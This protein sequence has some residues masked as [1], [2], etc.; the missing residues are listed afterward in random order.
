MKHFQFRTATLLVGGALA[1]LFAGCS[2]YTT[3]SADFHEAWKV[4]QLQTAQAEVSKK[5][6]NNS[7]NKDTVVWA[8]EEGAVFRAIALEN[9]PAPL[10][11]APAMGGQVNASYDLDMTKQSI[12][13]FDRAADRIATYD[14]QAGTKIASETGALLTNLANL[15]YRGRA[16][17]RIMLE[18][19]QA[20]NYMKLGDFDTA[21]VALNRVLNHQ[22]DAV[23]K[24]S[25]QIEEAQEQ[26][27][28]AKEGKISDEKGQSGSYDTEA[29]LKDPKT[30]AQLEEAEMELNTDV[31][32]YDVYVNPF[33]VFMDGLYFMTH[34]DGSSDMERSR[35]S[36]ER[37]A[38]MSPD[39]TYAREDLKLAE[40]L[41]YGKKPDGLTYLI[42]ETGSAPHLEQ[43]RID[44]PLF[45]VTSKVDYIACALPRLRRDSNF[46][47]SAAISV[48]E[49]TLQTQLLC[50]MDSVVAREFKN[51]WPAVLTKSLIT[52]GIKGAI[53]YEV[54][55]QLGKQGGYAGLLG[56]LAS[57]VFTATTTIADTRSWTT[58]PKEFQYA[59]FVTPQSRTITINAGGQ[60]KIVS[61]EPGKVNLV[62]VKNVAPG[63]PLLVSQIVLK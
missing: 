47:P 40:D 42:F 17:D 33:S 57:D 49:Q 43:L 9:Q 54:K 60:Q 26:A 39:N 35:K 20:L 19:Y 41:A 5:A 25:K 56:G 32:S 51:E 29:A 37:V 53:N 31:L 59:R 45:I 55:H 12:A 24:N 2:T 6:Q 36:F 63:L 50:S 18:T 62:Y 58:L 3:Q 14:E 10:T 28:K 11:A 52:T 1:L 44:I 8:L 15:S 38:G 21:R 22:R 46:V 7:D 13:A 61:I 4:G 34:G 48:G 27:A 30:A 23:E 16:S